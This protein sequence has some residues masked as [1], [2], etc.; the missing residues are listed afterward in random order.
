[1][2]G[3]L[4]ICEPFAM[5][6]RALPAL[7]PTEFVS[8]CICIRQ[9]PST[10]WLTLD[11]AS[12]IKTKW[13][14]MGSPVIGEEFTNLV[15]DWKSSRCFSIG[16][17]PR[18]IFRNFSSR[19]TNICIAIAGAAF[20]RCTSPLEWRSLQSRT[21]VLFKIRKCVEH[22]SVLRGFISMF[23]CFVS[24]CQAQMVHRP[25]RTMNAKWQK[26]WKL[27]ESDIIRICGQCFT[28]PSTVEERCSQKQPIV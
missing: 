21:W 12:W 14:Q 20:F 22:F 18:P 6:R 11:R 16:T 28:S 3:D 10:K 26:G 7:R 27:V 19:F 15:G 4:F 5:L 9:S 2:S 25:R 17:K 23:R 8:W 24:R 13:I 1:M